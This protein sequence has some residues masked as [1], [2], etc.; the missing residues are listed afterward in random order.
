MYTVQYNYIISKKESVNSKIYTGK[1]T[2]Q[3]YKY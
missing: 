1:D 3:I 2:T